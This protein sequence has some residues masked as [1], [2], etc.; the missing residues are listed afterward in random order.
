MSSIR[1]HADDDAQGPKVMM[2]LLM[3]LTKHLLGRMGGEDEKK[4]SVRCIMSMVITMLNI[5]ADSGADDE[6][7]G[8]DYAAAGLKLSPL[9]CHTR[10]SA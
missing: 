8:N 1:Y 5:C 4:L 6:K 3:W 2:L 7:D 9:F 10:A